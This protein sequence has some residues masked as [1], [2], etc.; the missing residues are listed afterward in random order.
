MIVW[1]NPDLTMKDLLNSFFVR[2]NRLDLMN[3]WEKKYCFIYNANKLSHFL[4]RNVK[5]ILSNNADIK[6]IRMKSNP[7]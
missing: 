4:E 2:I 6:F 7:G 3:N 5:N 1:I